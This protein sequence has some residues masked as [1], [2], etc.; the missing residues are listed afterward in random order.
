MKHEQPEMSYIVLQGVRSGVQGFVKL[1]T[2][3]DALGVTLCAQ[4][5]PPERPLR[6]LLLS[7]G[8]DGAALDLGGGAASGEGSV[9]W[10]RQQP[11]VTLALWDAVALA[12]DWPSGKLAAVGH[13]GAASPLWQL[14]ETAAHFLSVPVA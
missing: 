11:R 6:L 14:A 2:Q 7:A 10:S 1:E 4:G 9:Q 13:L 3:P 12:E 8:E 5:L